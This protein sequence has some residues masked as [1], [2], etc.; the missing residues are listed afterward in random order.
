MEKTPM[1]ETIDTIAANLS[2]LSKTID[3]RFATVDQQLADMKAQLGMKIEAVD[4]RVRL[5]YD[6][7]IAQQA[8]TAANELAHATFTNRLEDH[9]VRIL[10]LEPRK[11][12]DR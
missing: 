1:P 10:G 11:P 2:T 7:V 8:H 12:S 9:E 5:V 6:A 3:A 4:D